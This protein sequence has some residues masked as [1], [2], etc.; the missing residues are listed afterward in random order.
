[1]SGVIDEN[2]V[3]W[4]HC[5]VCGEMVRLDN[6]GYLPKSE[7]H[8]GVDICLACTNKSEWLE[9]VVPAKKWIAQFA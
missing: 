4:E 6:L 7:E 1:M 5:N 9:E 2:G 8:V 3:Q